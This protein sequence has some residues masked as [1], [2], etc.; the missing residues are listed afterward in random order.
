[1]TDWKISLS[2]LAFDEA[3]AA[4]VKE[5]VESRWLTQGPRTAE[6]EEAF[7]AFTGARYAVAVANCTA[8]LHLSLMAVGIGPGDRVV[9]PSMSFV[10]TANAVL[11]AGGE[12]VFADIVSVDRPF[13]DPAR[14]E[15]HLRAGA[16]AVVAMHYGGHPCGATALRELADRH[17]VPLV[18]DAAHA[19]GA[20]EGDR[21]AG[22]IGR[23]GC[24]S[25]FSNKNLATGEGGMV[26][27]DDEEAA[28]LL[29]RIRSHGMTTLTWDRHRGHAR[30]YDVTALG[31]NFRFDELRAAL[32]LV[33]LGKLES[34]NRR[35][36]E[37]SA[38]YR[39]R[40]AGADDVRVVWGD[41]DLDASACHLMAVLLPDREARDAA[42]EALA[43]KRIQ[44]SI[45][46]PPIHL[47]SFYRERG[48]E[49]SLPVT[50]EFA[51]RELTLPL[52]PG[53]KDEEV[54]LV[55]DALLEVV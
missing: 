31:Y 13:V 30:S 23:A 44:T 55:V 50:E 42:V 36:R 10:A 38:R 49:V 43:A 21:S 5:V 51:D 53:L 17:G 12:P 40:L 37:I 34:M 52:Y 29:R 14:V 45:H 39:E 18:E 24:F 48:A 2:D 20:R 8:A 35:R 6:L 32:G 26:V 28:E 25:F 54:D 3:E 16:K 46:Y 47:F 27:T 33:Q 19:P 4:A 9:V 11:H 1:M 41:G 7:A 15:E 22:T